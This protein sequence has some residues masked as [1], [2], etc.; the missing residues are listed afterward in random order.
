MYDSGQTAE[1]YPS[2]HV[3]WI[4][5]DHDDIFFSLSVSVTHQ[6]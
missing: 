1:L 5:V 6:E 4:K 3:Y 2:Y